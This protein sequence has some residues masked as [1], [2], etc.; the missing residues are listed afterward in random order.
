M[1]R[2]KIGNTFRAI[3]V[4]MRLRQLDVSARAGVSQQTV[5]DLECGRIRGLSV[6][7]YCRIA[8]ALDA[9]VP[10]TPRWR[11]PKPTLPAWRRSRS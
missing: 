5:S 11:G 6:D 9:D 7:V 10:L 2:V 8:E 4:D 3:R 1:D